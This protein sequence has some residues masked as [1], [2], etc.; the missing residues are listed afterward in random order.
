DGTEPQ[1]QA[2]DQLTAQTGALF[3]IAAGNSG[4]NSQTVSSPGSADTALTVA[5]VDRSDRLANFSS[6]GPRRGDGALKPEIA[7]PGV[8]IVA[9]RAGG[10]QIGDLYTSSTGTSMA[11]PHVAGA[12]AI[13]AQKYPDWTPE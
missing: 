4:P 2:V 11:T 6:R 3:V 1:D 5:A 7:A 13:L 9:A 10:A 12:A 8:G